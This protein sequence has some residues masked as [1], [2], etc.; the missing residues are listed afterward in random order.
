[1]CLPWFHDARGQRFSCA[2]AVRAKR[3]VCPRKYM[4]R[5]RNGWVAQV[6]QKFWLRAVM[7]LFVVTQSETFVHEQQRG[8]CVLEDS[9]LHHPFKSHA[10]GRLLHDCVVS[11]RGTPSVLTHLDSKSDLTIRFLSWRWRCSG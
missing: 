1:M 7:L 2:G 10:A 8:M 3:L 6:R 11:I 9:E 5:D 4:R